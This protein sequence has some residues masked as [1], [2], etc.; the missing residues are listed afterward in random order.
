MS[1]KESIEITLV[2]SDVC[3]MCSGAS[4]YSTTCPLKPLSMVLAGLSGAT[5][6]RMFLCT[7]TNLIDYWLA[8]VRKETNVAVIIAIIVICNTAMACVPVYTAPMSDWNGYM[9][10]WV[11]LFEAHHTQLI[12]TSALHSRLVG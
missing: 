8:I 2:Q 9:L 6:A 3:V 11:G 5:G 12:I 4:Y 1:K 7:T 10:G